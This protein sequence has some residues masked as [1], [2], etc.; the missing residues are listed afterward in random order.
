V[1]FYSDHAVQLYEVE[2]KKLLKARGLESGWGLQF[3]KD[4]RNLFA[5]KDG[6]SRGKP[7]LMELNLASGI[8]SLVDGLR[9][10]QN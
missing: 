6:N 8:V 7:V 5:L 2:S 3:S 1:A 4:G 9:F 10:K